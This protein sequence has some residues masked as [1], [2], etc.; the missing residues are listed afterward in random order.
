MIRRP[1]R[2]TLFPYTTLFRS[3][4]RALSGEQT[5][6]EGRLDYRS[7]G[8]RWVRATYL[9]DFDDQQRV[10]GFVALVTDISEE[11]LAEE[12]RFEE[13]RVKEGLARVG[14][15]LISDLDLESMFKRLTDEATALC[16]A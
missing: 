15:T 13:A 8:P 3:V 16:R 4:R 6:F 11:K 14:E 2:S 7:S 10:R 12:R 9:P 1:P 5:S